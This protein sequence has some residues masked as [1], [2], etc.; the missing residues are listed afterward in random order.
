[1]LQRATV[2]VYEA[3][4]IHL[5]LEPSLST[6]GCIRCFWRRRPNRTQNIHATGNAVF[7][8][9][10]RPHCRK[11]ASRRSIYLRAVQHSS[12]KRQTPVRTQPNNR[13]R[14]RP[15]A[16]RWLILRAHGAI[17]PLQVD[18]MARYRWSEQGLA[19]GVCVRVA[20]V[21]KT[22][23]RSRTAPGIRPDPRVGRCLDARLIEGSRSC[24][25]VTN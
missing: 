2:I 10:D 11:P 24:S 21:P 18:S 14:A 4:L 7:S 6:L 17:R 25:A 8:L 1:M 9:F 13:N 20:S 15:C 12:I 5:S 16:C 23:L 19:P 22:R 3:L